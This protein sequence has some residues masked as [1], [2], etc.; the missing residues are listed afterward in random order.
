MA[1][2]CPSCKQPTTE[3]KRFCAD[4]GAPLDSVV[5]TDK[6]PPSAAL[7][8]QIRE[9][10]N[11]KYKDQKLVELETSQAIVERLANWAKLLAFFVGI[12]IAGLLLLFGALGIKTYSDFSHLVATAEKDIAP[13]ID[14]AQ[15]RAAKL[16]SDSEALAA[17]YEKLRAQ[18]ADSAAL[19]SQVRTLSAKVDLIG[20]KLGFTPSSKVSTELKRRLELAFGRFQQYLAALGYKSKSDQIAISIPERMDQPGALS[21]YDPDKKMMVIDS[22]YAADPDLL[23]REYMHH[24]LYSGRGM[25]NDPGMKLWT[26]YAIES[27]L[28]T[29]FSCSFT[30]NPKSTEKTAALIGGSFHV[31]DLD[32]KRPF[33]ELRPDVGAAI[34][35]GTEIWGGA[36]WAMR[37][38]LGKQ[39][40]DKL[41]FDAW[42]A[43]KP[44]DVRSDKGATFVRK[45][46]DLDKTLAGGEHQSEIREIFRS[47]GLTL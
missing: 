36:F 11:E 12:P 29:Y 1:I 47:R 2:V 23:Y 4:C 27:G 21:Y 19:A 8:E 9:V 22:K 33:S 17:D 40:A 20:E 30:D 28:A 34:M 14:D 37:K 13:K 31:W 25:P 46:I 6:T 38:T 5:A 18:L 3:G 45:L 42:F 15:K 7:V 35:D 39:V 10:I 26:Y 41:L 44:D 32:N 16:K 43:L 24:V